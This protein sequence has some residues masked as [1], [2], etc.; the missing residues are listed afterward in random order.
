MF[1]KVLIGSALCTVGLVVLAGLHHRPESCPLARILDINCAS[2]VAADASS[3]KPTL[4]GKWGKKQGELT[5]EFAEGDVLKIAPHGDK[6]MLAIVCDYRLEKEGLVKVKVTR[7]EGQEEITKKVQ[8]HVPVGLEF[9]FKWKANADAARLEDVKGGENID[10]LKSHLE[11]E[12]EK[13]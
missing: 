4:S 13:K 10:P 8:E 1:L 5:M 12:F 7:L 3:D 11:G 6:I 2:A 9:N